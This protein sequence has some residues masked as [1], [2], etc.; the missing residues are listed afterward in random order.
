VLFFMASWCAP[1]LF[2]AE[3]LALLNER[4]RGRGLDIIAVDVDPTT[5]RA[6]L[7]AFRA[8]IRGGDYHWA[9]DA[10]GRLAKAFDVRVLDTT[11]VI[12]RDRRIVY[13]DERLT[14]YDEL[15]AVVAPLLQ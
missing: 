10:G 4:F 6:D 3:M 7:E 1:C 15:H 14:R 8:G 13:R 11:V 9:L 2:E 5:R 12:D